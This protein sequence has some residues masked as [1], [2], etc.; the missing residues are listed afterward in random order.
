[1]KTKTTI[2]KKGRTKLN[3]SKQNHNK[4]SKTHKH[5]QNKTTQ[6]KTKLQKQKK[7]TQT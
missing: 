5:K 1:M 6:S 2:L 7:P 3:K 4:C